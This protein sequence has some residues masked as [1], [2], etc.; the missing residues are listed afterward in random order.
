MTAPYGDGW[1]TSGTQTGATVMW[2]RDDGNWFSSQP[3]AEGDKGIHAEVEFGD[4]F[5][6]SA[7]NARIRWEYNLANINGTTNNAAAMVESGGL[8]G[9]RHRWLRRGCGNYCQSDATP[10]RRHGG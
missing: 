10:R 3:G 9:E 5:F 8:G 1:F 6:T 2:G 7:A 4:T